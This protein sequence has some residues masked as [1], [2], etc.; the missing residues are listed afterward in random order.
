MNRNCNQYYLLGQKILKEEKS[1]KVEF[2]IGVQPNFKTNKYPI[3][4]FTGFSSM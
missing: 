1:A 3:V 4:K 2:K